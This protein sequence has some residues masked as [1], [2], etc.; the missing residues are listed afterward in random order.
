MQKRKKKHKHN[1]LEEQATG[2]FV[3]TGVPG[4]NHK[5]KSQ[6]RKN[7]FGYDHGAPDQAVLFSK[8]LSYEAI[9]RDSD[10][11]LLSK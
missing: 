11:R 9:L 1:I 7:Q 3:A 4:M 8:K 5:N 10:T 6:K 2:G